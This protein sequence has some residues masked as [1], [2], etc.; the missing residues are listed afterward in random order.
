MDNTP[1]PKESQQL[2]LITA[3]L[4]GFALGLLL[5]IFKPSSELIA[6]GFMVLGGIGSLYLATSWYLQNSEAA[7]E[8][9]SLE[10][11]LFRAKEDKFDSENKLRTTAA[12]LVGANSEISRLR[13]E[14]EIHTRSYEKKIR[15][16]VG[17][18]ITCRII[19]ICGF[20]DL[21]QIAVSVSEDGKAYA[22]Y[23]KSLNI[24]SL[25]KH[26]KAGA[27]LLVLLDEVYDSIFGFPL[28]R[29]SAS[30]TSIPETLIKQDNPFVSVVCCNR[31]AG[32]HSD[33][34]AT[35]WLTKSRLEEIQNALQERIDVVLV[36]EDELESC[37]SKADYKALFAREKKKKISKRRRRLE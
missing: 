10:A 16:L 34:L 29:L 30:S 6:L 12:E 15:A 2:K 4:G 19:E 27:R 28:V 23:T 11:K 37:Q 20:D 18:I 32:V 3:T 5:F 8:K 1:L 17:S 14:I 26:I 22:V 24:P 33:I 31:V 21:I 13:N 25:S 36:G 35:R 9:K 7:L